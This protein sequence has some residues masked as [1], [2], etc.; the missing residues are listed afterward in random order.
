MKKMKTMKTINEKMKTIV[1]ILALAGISTT[2]LFASAK[3]NEKTLGTVNPV[4]AESVISLAPV[5]P[6]VADFSDGA[7]VVEI[8]I[9]D[10]SPITPVLADFEELPANENS[11]VNDMIA[12]VPPSTATFEDNE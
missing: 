8:S 7:P 2:T 9:K 5:T 6:L 3:G 11:I 4:I 12:P 1:V 10:I